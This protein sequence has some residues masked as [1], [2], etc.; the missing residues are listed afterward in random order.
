[1]SPLNSTRTHIAPRL[2]LLT[3]VYQRAHLTAVVLAAYQRIQR[4]LAGVVD[5]HLLAVGSEGIAS[6]SLCEQFGFDYLEHRNSPLS[7][8]WNAGILATR[9]YDP[10]GVIIVGSDD[11]VSENLFRVYG[12]KL[13][14]GLDFFG[15]R[16]LYFYNAISQRLGYWSGYGTASPDRMD[17]PIGCGRCYSRSLLRATDWN[18][19]PHA[20]ARESL[21]DELTMV[22]LQRCGFAPVAFPM[23][24]LGVRAV[25]VKVGKN[26]T[27]FSAYDYERSWDGDEATAFLG[28]WLTA[29]QIAALVAPRSLVVAA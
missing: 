26:I 15:L 4:N 29:A 13:T 24:Q 3:C 7:D 6:Q 27:P 25:D 16:D 28:E 18:L 21:L 8:K 5:L 22:H 23:E 19:W 2:V 20:Q 11:L 10:D 1:M 12:E 14:E 9:A 17:E